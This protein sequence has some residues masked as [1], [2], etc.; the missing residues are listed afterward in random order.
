MKKDIG[1]QRYARA[2]NNSTDNSTITENP[3][4]LPNFLSLDFLL[5]VFLESIKTKSGA[6]IFARHI[7]FFTFESFAS[8]RESWDS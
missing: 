5:E 8:I 4:V 7:C 2:I 1:K 6:N 3:K